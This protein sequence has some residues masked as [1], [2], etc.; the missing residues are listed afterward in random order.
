MMAANQHEPNDN[1]TEPA[2]WDNRPSATPTL[3]QI[4][5]KGHLHSDWSDWLEGLELTLL[6]TGEMLLSGPL[7]DQA[8]LMGVLNKLGRLNLALISVNELKSVS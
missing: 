1:P 2:D 5:V 6:D 8:A 7:V 3:Y 4:R